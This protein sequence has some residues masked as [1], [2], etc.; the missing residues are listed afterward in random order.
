M[1]FLFLGK[2]LEIAGIN[3]N[4]SPLH[5]VLYLNTNCHF[6]RESTP[7]YREMADRL[8]GRPPGVSL[9]VFSVESPEVMKQ[10]LANEQIAVDG[11]YKLPS[12][13]A[14]MT[15]TPT[16]FI[17][18]ANG[19]VRRVFIGK[20]DGAQEKELLKIVQAGVV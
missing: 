12:S 8:L 5:A 18:D 15:G 13:V 19:I 17:L 20:L 11:I 6:C 14:G 3:W 16:W 10:Y 2:H 9:S 7:F 4:S 1:E